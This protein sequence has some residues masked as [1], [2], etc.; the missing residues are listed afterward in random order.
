MMKKTIYLLMLSLAIFSCQKEE[1][2]DNIAT[3]ETANEATFKSTTVNS[4]SK[5]KSAISNA[6]A[7]DKIIVSGT[8]KLTSTL[9]CSKSGTSS[10]KIELSGGTLDC[11]KMK[12]GSRG[13]DPR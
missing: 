13:I 10:K 7:G 6:K 2:F 1:L 9:K 4:E 5:L 12:S 3:D 8:I 11:S